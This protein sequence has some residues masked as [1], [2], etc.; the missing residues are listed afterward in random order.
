[1]GKFETYTENTDPKGSETIVADA[2]ADTERIPLGVLSTW[3][4]SVRI[5]TES[6]DTLSG[7]AARDGITPVAGNRVLVKAQSTASANGIYDAASGA[8][9]RS[10]DFDTS[11]KAQSGTFIVVQ[12]G[13]VNADK[14]FQLTTNEPITLGSTSL[15]FSEFVGG[16]GGEANTISSLGGGSSGLVAGTPKSGVDLRT[17]SLS[18]TAPVTKSD[19]SDLITIDLNDLANAD[20]SSS[21]AIVLSKLQDIATD[22]ILGREAAGSGSIEELTLNATLEL[23][24]GAIRR[25]ALTG[26]ITSSAGSNATIIAAGVII[27]ADINASAAIVNS[28]LAN[29]A[30][31][32]IIG[33]ITGGSGV[34]EELTAANVLSIIGVEAGATADQ[35]NAE[36]KTAYEANA[37]TN[38]FDDAEQTKLGGIETAADVTDATNVNA[39]GATMNADTDVSANGYVLD[40]DTMSSDDNTKVATQQSVKAYVDTEVAAAIVGD[41]TLKGDY[42]AATNTPDLD[43]SPSGILKGDHYI[44]SVAGTFFSTPL[45]VGDSIIAEKDNPT[46]VTD[47]IL[48]QTNLTPATIKTAYESNADTNEF[49]DAEQTNLGN[50]SG[51]NTGDEPD[52]DLST[53]GIVELATIAEVDT[54]TD[55]TRAVTPDGLEGSALQ[56]KVDGVEAGA[57]ADQTN[58]EIKTAYEANSNTNEFDDTEQSKLAGIATGAEVNPALISQAEAEAGTA[59][60][61]RI[62][63][64]LRV[65]QAIAALELALYVHPNHTGDVTSIADGATLIASNIIDNANINSAAAILHSKLESIVVATDQANTYSAATIQTIPGHGAHGA[66]FVLV[67]AS[68]LPASP[69]AGGMWIESVLNQLQYVSS[70]NKTVCELAL[71]QVLTNKSIDSDNNTITNL[72]NADIKATAAILNSKLADIAT[73]RI[74]GRIS[75]GSGVREEL[76]GTQVTTLLNNFTDALKGLVPLSGGG[77]TKFLRADA[78]W[79]V[80]GGSSPLTTKG[81]IFGYDTSDERIPIGSN[82]QVLT[83]DSAQALGLKWATP[84]GGGGGTFTDRI[85]C[86]LEVPEGIVAYPDIIPLATQGSKISGFVLP[87]ATDSTINF[88]VIVPDDLAGTP[89]AIIRIYTLTLSANTTDAV[90]LTLNMRY[91]GD[92]ENMDQAFNQTV[93]AT[94]YNVADTIESIDIHDIN[95]STD[96]AAKDIITG[97]IFRDISLD[98][99]GDIMIVGIDLIIDREAP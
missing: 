70:G 83:A 45:E 3:K 15:T 25:A 35:T 58:A 91:T 12:E 99:A 63:S 79:V 77:T 34:R 67:P 18:V 21:A 16:G 74:L 38:E 7:L 89:N 48:V 44:V 24:S 85:P 56:A 90:N 33:R 86:V 65:A 87:T 52:A 41:I 2:G 78:T 92:T 27:N 19:S 81:D 31:A 23:V 66:S 57:T 6:N 50:Q 55:A 53:K 61:E 8:W 11:P 93:A 14:V 49:S 9:S 72:V 36:I 88:K 40:E 96:P 46:V 62:F 54:G 4:K 71:A 13:S 75:G 22:R 84:S 37:D 68:G 73:A 69:A 17:K 51:T 95:P 43:T 28:K 20:I 47:W 76:T 32:R 26:D 10:A 1:M 42:N 98:A 5:A 94:N 29:I 97:Q 80:P 30:T 39:A 59:T 60:T 82:D 64:A